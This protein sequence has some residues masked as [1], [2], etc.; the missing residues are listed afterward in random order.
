MGRVPAEILSKE[1]GARSILFEQ[2]KQQDNMVPANECSIVLYKVAYE[3]E[4][5]HTRHVPVFFRPFNEL[6]PSD[7]M[8]AD[9]NLVIL[10]FRVYPEYLLYSPLLPQG[11]NHIITTKDKSVFHRFPV[12]PIHTLRRP[13]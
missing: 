10:Y 11:L 1:E 3:K 6:R 12:L 9:A 13:S 8:P 7:V 5:C 4:F 2:S